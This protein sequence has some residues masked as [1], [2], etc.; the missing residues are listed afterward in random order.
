MVGTSGG[1]VRAVTYEFWG[2]IYLSAFGRYS[3][4]LLLVRIAEISLSHP[5]VEFKR[6][7]SLLRAVMCCG[8]T[9][10]P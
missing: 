4:L 10:L 1:W 9:R 3:D 5:G 8:L 2:Q 6:E 7:A